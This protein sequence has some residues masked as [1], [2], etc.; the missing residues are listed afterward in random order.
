MGN[1]DCMAIGR[2]ERV[3]G[4]KPSVLQAWSDEGKGST[5]WKTVRT[6]SPE[7]TMAGCKFFSELENLSELS[8][9]ASTSIVASIWLSMSG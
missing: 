2:L 4:S 5:V 6:T 7:T 9:V 1:E 3:R 8:L